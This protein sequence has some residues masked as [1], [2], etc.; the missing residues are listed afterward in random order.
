MTRQQNPLGALAGVV[1][2]VLVVQSAALAQPAPAAAVPSP[3]PAPA[4]FVR[5]PFPP[6]SSGD[7]TLRVPGAPG[8]EW[9][10]EFDQPFRA[11]PPPLAQLL[12]LAQLPA[13]PQPPAHFSRPADL[14]DQALHSIERGQLERAIEQLD[15]LIQQFEGKAAATAAANKVDGAFYW[16]AYTQVRKRQM[17]DALTTLEVMQKKFSSSRWSKDAKAL[18]VEARQASGQAVSPDAQA[19]EELKLLALRGIMQSDPAH[20]VPMIEQLLGGN[21]SVQVKENALFVLSLS[22]T[23][24]AREIINAVAKGGANPELQLRAVRYLGAMGGAE[25]RQ[26]LDDVYRS[27][28]DASIK[29]AVI[30]SFMTSG[31]RERLRSIA[32]SES[33]PELRGEAI[34]LLGAMRAAPELSGLYGRES[35]VDIRKHIMQ[36]LLVTG[37]ADTLLELARSEKDEQLRRFAVRNLGV[38]RASRTGEALRALYVSESSPGVKQE[39]INALSGQRNAAALVDLARAEKDPAVKREIVSKLSVMKSK[40]ATD[41]LIELLK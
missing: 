11:A 30:R 31:D 40:E 34:Q 37:N 17:A 3:W 19:D 13:P 21:S 25:N 36:A 1:V 20:G 32:G 12:A 28:T 29:R 24:R 41:Y 14:Y 27:T 39:V 26:V 16:K 9:L 8:A 38:M 10:A 23:A 15:R 4:P 6:G 5:T 2:L 35:S 18:E 22:R 7:F 33:A